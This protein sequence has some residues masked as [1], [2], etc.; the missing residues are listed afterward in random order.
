MRF[1]IPTPTTSEVA[2]GPLTIH[3]YALCI[4]TGV[5][6]AIWLTQRRFSVYGTQTR[7]I[8]SDVAV[9]AVPAGVIG[10]RLYHVLTTPEKYFGRN[11]QP[12]DALKIWEGGLG[13]W[14]AIALG[15]LGASIAYRALASSR[16]LPTFP[17][18]LDALAP[19]VIFAQAIGRWGNWF[20]G[21]LFGS[22]LQAPWALE[23]P[24]YLRPSGYA[25]FETFH[26][27]FLYEFIWCTIV[28][29]A[30]I[31]F[32]KSARGASM[33]AGSL[34]LAYVATYCAGRFFIEG[35]RIDGAH[36]FAGLRVNHYV[37]LIL[38]LG[39]GAFFTLNLRRSR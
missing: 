31:L 28:G 11:G 24:T 21:E 36:T 14:G 18:F 9:V 22:P 8:V 5:A 3:F 6:V 38:G 4:I 17:H 19:G 33:P 34:F 27:T 2:L 39:A 12:L 10:G 29:I 1:S 26:P 37:S 25:Q 15:A 7:G 13:I 30:L 16:D 20:N 23:I 32:G 35:V